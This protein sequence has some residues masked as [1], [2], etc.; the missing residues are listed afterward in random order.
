[1]IDTVMLGDCFSEMGK[2]NDNS[3]DL[4]ITDPPYG[5]SYVNNYTKQRHRQIYGDRGI[6]YLN[7]AKECYRV[8]ANN[9]NAYIFTRFD[10]YAEHFNAL[11]EAGFDITNCLV[12]EKGN[13]GGCGNLYSSFS[14]NSEWCI[15]CSK[16]KRNFNHTELVKNK[17]AG[18]RHIRIGK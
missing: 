17:K 9:T 14:C 3:I 7:F 11:K 18:K 16:G 13:I 10:K 5:I 1:M 15:F 6:D 4:I 2:I 8:L 12:I